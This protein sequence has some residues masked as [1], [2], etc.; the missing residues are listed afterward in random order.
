MTLLKLSRFQSI[1]RCYAILVL[2]CCYL[3]ANVPPFF[4]QSSTGKM[5]DSQ[6]SCSERRIKTHSLGMGI[7]LRKTQPFYPPDAK[8]AG[9]SG[10]VVLEA[11]MSKTGE[12]KDIRVVSG[13]TML[14]Q[15]SID[16]VRTWRYRPYMRD[17]VPIEA[18]ITVNVVFTLGENGEADV[19]ATAS[20]PIIVETYPQA[21]GDTH[22][23]P[24]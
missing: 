21:T 6:N 22:P 5:P 4:A 11:T 15:A 18:K 1:R 8:T 23:V 10:K 13:H 16:A 20:A 14:Q 19:K 24:N 7:L 12:V 2:V 9:I 3:C 17:G